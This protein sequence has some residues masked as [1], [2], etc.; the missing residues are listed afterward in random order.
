VFADACLRDA[1]IITERIARIAL[2][3]PLTAFGRTEH[4]D[5]GL[6]IVAGAADWDAGVFDQFKTHIARRAMSDPYTGACIA[7]RRLSIGA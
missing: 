3:A 2:N 7:D 4:P 5:G 6:A 1:C